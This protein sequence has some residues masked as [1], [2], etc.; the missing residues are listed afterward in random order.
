MKKNKNNQLNAD[1]I[2][3][4]VVSI[5]LGAVV[6]KYIWNTVLVELVPSIRKIT[7]SQF[8]LLNVLMGMLFCRC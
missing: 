1:F 8:I 6:G 4:I 7:F 3:L 2:V 5:I